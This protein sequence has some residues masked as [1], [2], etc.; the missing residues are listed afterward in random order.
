MVLLLLLFVLLSVF[1]IAHEADHECT[2]E[3][4][5][6]CALIQISENNLRQLGSG[7]PAAAA[8]ISCIVFVMMLQSLTDT[9]IVISTPVS[10]KIR[11][12]N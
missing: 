3:D 10:R 12:N 2:G 11:L 5:P 8:V 1:F 7:A 6:V 9:G 4:C